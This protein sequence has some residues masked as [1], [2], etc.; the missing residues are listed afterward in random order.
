MRIKQACKPRAFTSCPPNRG[1]ARPTEDG[2]V[3][4]LAHRSICATARQGNQGNCSR[5]M[6]AFI[7]LPHTCMNLCEFGGTAGVERDEQMFH[8]KTSHELRYHF[9]RPTVLML[10][11][12]RD[13]LLPTGGVSQYRT[14]HPNGEYAV[15]SF[16]SQYNQTLNSN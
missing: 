12:C 9:Y 1:K 2:V 6:A 13:V 4:R 8:N 14:I 10:C 3:V 15:S 16:L 7:F 11:V 5:P